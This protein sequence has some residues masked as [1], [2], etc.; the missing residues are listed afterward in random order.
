LYLYD[1]KSDEIKLNFLLD[2]IG[3]L[4]NDT[5]KTISNTISLGN[6]TN[7]QFYEIQ[8]RTWKELGKSDGE[9]NSTIEKLEILITLY[10]EF[11]S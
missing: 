2:N 5:I 10:V 11:N 4:D 1:D 3:A 7:Q 8:S 6:L 9:T